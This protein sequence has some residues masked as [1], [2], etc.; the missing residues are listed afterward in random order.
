[1]TKLM[2][3]ALDFA[4]CFLTRTTDKPEIAAESNAKT[5]PIMKLSFS[6]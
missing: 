4:E 6:F 3:K 5:M 1:M 2:L